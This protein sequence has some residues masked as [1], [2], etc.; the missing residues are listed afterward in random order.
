MLLLPGC[1]VVGGRGGQASTPRMKRKQPGMCGPPVAA[2]RSRYCVG[3]SP[4]S[5]RKRDENEPRLE[6]PTIM[7]TSVTVRLA[8]P[9]QVLRPLD[10]PPGEVAHR[11]VPVGGGERA[12]EVVLR[13]VGGRRR[14][15]RGRAARRSACRPGRGPAAG[16]GRG[17]AGSRRRVSHPFWPLSGRIRPRPRPAHLPAGVASNNPRW[18]SSRAPARRAVRDRGTRR[19]DAWCTISARGTRGRPVGQA[20]PDRARSVFDSP[21]PSEHTAPTSSTRATSARSRWPPP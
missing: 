11:R 4:T 8:R 17:P 6:N 14:G 10:A 9:Q 21:P 5:S 15:R 2:Q 13:H 7:Q 16:A 19:P 1:G 18:P 20:V 12:G 3:V